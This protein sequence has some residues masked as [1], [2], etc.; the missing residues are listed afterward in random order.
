MKSNEIDEFY[1]EKKN[2]IDDKI[3]ILNESIE[4]IRNY[5]NH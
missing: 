4:K 3:K 1:D 5:M 2:C